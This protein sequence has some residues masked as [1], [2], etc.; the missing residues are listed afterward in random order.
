MAGA[1]EVRYRPEVADRELPGT[2]PNFQ[3]RIL[4]AVENRLTTERDRYGIRL[5]K[6]LWGVWKLRV[7]DYRIVYEIKEREV[8]S[9]SSR[10]AGR[11]TR[12][13][14]GGRR[15]SGDLIPDLALLGQHFLPRTTV[16]VE[17]LMLEDLS[18]G[19]RP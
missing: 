1:Y 3:R 4:K 14:S 6:S 2:P 7:G 8:P 9:G 17:G 5:R 19:Q 15:G 12:W 18:W 13:L 16:D 10:T 11:C